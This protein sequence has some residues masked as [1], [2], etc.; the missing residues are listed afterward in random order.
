MGSVEY[1]CC[2]IGHKKDDWTREKDSERQKKLPIPQ[3]L[4][5]IDCKTPG[6]DVSTR[7]VYVYK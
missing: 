6:D 1:K 5:F 4:H 7:V 3:R 2:W